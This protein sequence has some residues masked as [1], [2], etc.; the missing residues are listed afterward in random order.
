MPAETSTRS[1]A[2]CQA[3]RTAPPL[4]FE[5]TMAFQPIVDAARQEIWGYE[6]LVRGVNGEGA[7]QILSQVTPQTLYPF[8]QKCR[9]RAIELAAELFDPESGAIL[10]INFMPNAVYEPRA[11]IRTS[12]Q[13]ARRTGF[14]PR[15]LMFEFNET[16]RVSDPSHVGNIL[17]TYRQLGFITAIDDFG[18]GYSGLSLLADFQ[19]NLVKIDRSLIT[20]IDTSPARQAIIAGIAHM[21]RALDIRLIAE[22]VETQ[23]EFQVLR[24][25]GISLFQGYLFA[26][27]GFQSLPAVNAV[28]GLE[29][30]V[31]AGEVRK[32]G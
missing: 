9:V 10:S 7:G 18:A 30:A 15:R 19:P 12:M 14:D 13:A 2:P 3:C 20:D 21:A 32:A 6:A 4:P 25:A 17:D 5:I 24:A 16:E 22:G 27:P 1:E 8:D 23:A 26:R 28:A 11:C 31:E 29:F